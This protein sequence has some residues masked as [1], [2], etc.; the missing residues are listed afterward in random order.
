MKLNF[1]TVFHKK[2]RIVNFDLMV[3]KQTANKDGELEAPVR[4]SK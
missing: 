2:I 1:S 3:T 4:L